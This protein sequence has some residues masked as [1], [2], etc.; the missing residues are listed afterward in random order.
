[1]HIEKETK[2]TNFLHFN[3]SLLDCFNKGNKGAYIQDSDY[4][5]G[6]VLKNPAYGRH[7][8]SRPMQIVGPIQI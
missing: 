1:M 2:F 6:F 3:L 8:L 7:Q 4:I 5:L